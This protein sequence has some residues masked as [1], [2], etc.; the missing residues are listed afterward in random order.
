MPSPEEGE[1]G[2]LALF[3]DKVFGML[4]ILQSLL[5]AIFPPW[6]SSRLPT[7]PTFLRLHLGGNLP[8]F[9]CAS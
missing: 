8:C 1:S 9:F 3:R 6:Q 5:V 4:Y 2:M 7:L